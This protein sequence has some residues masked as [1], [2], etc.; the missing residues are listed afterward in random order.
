[1]IMFTKL[2]LLQSMDIQRPHLTAFGAVACA[3]CFHMPDDIA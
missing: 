3:N 1:M 2:L